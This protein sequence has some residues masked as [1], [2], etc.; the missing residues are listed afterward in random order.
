MLLSIVYQLSLQSVDFESKIRTILIEK[1][2]TRKQLLSQELSAIAS[3]F[4][5]LLLGRTRSSP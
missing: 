2:M 4:R 1:R 5:D 3:L